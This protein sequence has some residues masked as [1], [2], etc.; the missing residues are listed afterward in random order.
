ME[1]VDFNA[2]GVSFVV[3]VDVDVCYQRKGEEE[4]E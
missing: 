4:E 1:R 3:V 2:N